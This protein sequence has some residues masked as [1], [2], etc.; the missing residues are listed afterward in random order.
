MDLDLIQVAAVAAIFGIAGLV[1]GIIGLG[2]PTIAIALMGV[3]LPIE[4]AAAILVLPA[5]LTN[6]WQMWAGKALIALLIRLWPMLA[7]IVI[8]TV[9]AASVL[10]GADARLSSILLGVVLA[11]Y[12]VVSL[13]GAQFPVTRDA[14][15][16][17]GPLMGVATGV[18]NGATAIFVI[19][20]VPYLQALD[21]DRDDFVQAIGISAFTS[22]AALALGLG[23]NSGL[24]DAVAVPASI[25]VAAAFAGMAFGQTVRSKLSVETFRRFVLIG[26][27]TLGCAMI[28][29]ALV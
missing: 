11:V 15:P 26:L 18:I 19:P 25:A 12:A 2:L 3:W 4:Q 8:A 23:L 13:S 7:G 28:I 29:R 17:V 21:L 16:T 9:A 24:S 14:E 22:V 1:K 5:L 27:L 20:A 10:A 6:V